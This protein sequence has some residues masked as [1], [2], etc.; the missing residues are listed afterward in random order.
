MRSCFR[1]AGVVL[2]A[3]AA[4]A[5]PRALA[6]RAVILDSVTVRVYDSA[7]VAASDRNAALRTAASILS[8]ADLDVAWIVCTS[9]RDHRSQAACDAAPAGHELVVRLTNSTPA[10]EDGNRRA[11]GYSLLDAATGSGALS[12]VFVDRVDWLAATGKAVRA[13]ILGRAI[14][15]EL[16]HLMLG[17][18]DHT[19]RGLMRETWTAEELMRNRA[20]DWQFSPA[21]RASLRARWTGSEA[22]GRRAAGRDPRAQPSGG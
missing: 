12:T 20:E 14:A 7:G 15:H 3:L 13:E 18:N 11:F 19:A 8:R 4:V 5:V 6:A 2:M 9:P 22:T 10:S 17:S 1:H 21:Q 16:G